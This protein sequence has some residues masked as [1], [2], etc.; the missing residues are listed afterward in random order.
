MM[1][2][3]RIKVDRVVGGER[4][5]PYDGGPS[6]IALDSG[7][8]GLILRHPDGEDFRYL[9]SWPIERGVRRHRI[10]LDARKQSRARADWTKTMSKKASFA[11]FR[12]RAYVESKRGGGPAVPVARGNID[13]GG[14]TVEA[15]RESIALG[16]DYLVRETDDRGRITYEYDAVKNAEGTGYNMLRHAGTLYSMMQAWRVQ[17]D[18]ALLAASRRAADYYI[19]RLEED[20]E[21][22]PDLRES[23]GKGEK[24]GTQGG[25]GHGRSLLEKNQREKIICCFFFSPA[26]QT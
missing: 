12:T 6:G 4:S 19:S 23:F 5:I 9:P 15:L 20:E 1:A 14:V 3:S 16:A 22:S 24:L 18:P 8:D 13:I 21:P 17:P 7:L 11:A 10:H 2:R 25:E 26:Y